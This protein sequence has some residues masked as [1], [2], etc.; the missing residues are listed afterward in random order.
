MAGDGRGGEGGRVG[1]GG[2]VGG[3]EEGGEGGKEGVGGL[4]QIG[5]CAILLPLF[6]PCHTSVQ[7]TSTATQCDEMFKVCE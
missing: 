1:E 2:S 6:V 4:N 7:Q 5:G 3:R